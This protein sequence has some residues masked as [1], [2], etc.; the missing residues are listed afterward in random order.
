MEDAAMVSQRAGAAPDAGSTG[1]DA[2]MTGDRPGTEPGGAPPS[3]QPQ[4]TQP[5]T[6]NAPPATKGPASA[7]S[8]DML[9]QRAEAYL[10]ALGSGDTE[11]LNLAPEARYTENG[12][13][14][15]I[16]LG[17]W[18]SRPKSQFARH[19]LDEVR[20]SSVT[21]AV[22]G[23]VLSRNILGLRLRLVNGQLLEIEAQVV[24]RNT[25]YY[26]PDALIS[27]GND[28]WPESVP[29]ATRMSR[30]ALMLLAEHYFDSTTN[31]SLLPPRAPE[32]RRRQNGA[33]FDGLE[34]C[35]VP[36]SDRFEQL[37]FPV[38]DETAGIVT[39]IMLYRGHVGL[40]LIK[41]QSDTIQSIDVIG[42]ANAT[43]SGW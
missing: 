15:T 14:Q 2:G 27:A 13:V 28:L 6:T 36:A 34:H 10:E 11:P 42:G 23:D 37:R 21:V 35:D 17:L 41:A 22:V 9:R 19:V 1:E 38:T 33:P 16:G 25:S 12:S 20:C 4:S 8:R 24:W 5:S 18:L 39:A 43:N 40:Y 29:E 30:D 26:D 32:C 7:C 31:A 3:T